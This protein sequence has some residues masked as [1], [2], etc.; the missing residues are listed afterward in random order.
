VSAGVKFRILNQEGHE[1]ETGSRG[2][3]AITGDAVMHGYHNKQDANSTSFINGWF[4]TGDEGYIDRDG[5]LYIVGRIKELINRGGEKVS[6]VEVEE[7]LLRHPHISEAACFGMPDP[8]YGEEIHAAVV[9]RDQA[10]TEEITSFCERH[11]AKIKVPKEIHVVEQLPRNATNKVQRQ[12][13]VDQ[14]SRIT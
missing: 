3:V 5:Y 4:L 6:P 9:L 8:K 2:Q 12:K 7:V 10:S 14:F 11:L 13:L 1:L